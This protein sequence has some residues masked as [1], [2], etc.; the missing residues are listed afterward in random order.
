[1]KWASERKPPSD[2]HRDEV[3]VVGGGVVVVAERKGRM[4]GPVRVGRC[5]DVGNKVD[6]LAWFK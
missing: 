2:V 1:M 6:S 5:C 4:R 3:D